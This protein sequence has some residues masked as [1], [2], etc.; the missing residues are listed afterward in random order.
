MF[1]LHVLFPSMSL[2]LEMGCQTLNKSRVFAKILRLGF[3]IDLQ[4]NLI[5]MTC[6]AYTL[7][8]YGMHNMQMFDGEKSVQCSMQQMLYKCVSKN[9][10]LPN[11]LLDSSQINKQNNYLRKKK[12][13]SKLQ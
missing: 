6:W 8:N 10:I 12:K 5:M 11:V 1:Y 3:W 7:Q 9:G 2:F 4:V 13:K